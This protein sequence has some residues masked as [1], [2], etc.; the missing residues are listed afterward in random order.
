MPWIITITL[1]LFGLIALIYSY[2]I[3]RIVQALA[4]VTSWPQSRI[5]FIT[6]FIFS[7]L[8]LFPL[9]FL[10]AFLVWG[11][12]IVPAFSGEVFLL[13]VVF[14]YPFWFCL[15]VMVQFIALLFLMDLIR[16]VSYPVYRRT[17]LTWQVW[18]SRITVGLLAALTIYSA[19]VIADDTWRVRIRETAVTLPEGAE[20]LRGLRIVHISDVQGDGRTTTGML[21]AYVANVNALNPDL[22]IFTGDLV[23]SGTSYIR[24]TAAILGKVEAKY[25]RVAVL[26]DHDYFSDKSRVVEAL[27]RNGWEILQDSAAVVHVGDDSLCLTGITE[28]YRKRVKLEELSGLL[29]QCHRIPFRIAIVHQPAEQIVWAAEAAGYQ[30]FLA[31]HTHGG[32][33]AFGIPG[34]FLLAPA[35]LESRFMSGFYHVGDLL[36]VVNNGI[37]LTLAP[38]RFHAPAE[39]TVLDLGSPVMR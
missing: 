26:G 37:G 19:V 30:L 36:V 27:S 25:R 38:F 6:I 21:N 18:Q 8:N 13:D 29:A 17:R 35:R 11:R 28:T 23:T 34:I 20:G 4:A 9:V 22:V 12:R 24:S 39:I 14:V 5:R 1:L 2:G 7:F 3:R 31:G 32:G 10:G 16:L 15:V 33:I